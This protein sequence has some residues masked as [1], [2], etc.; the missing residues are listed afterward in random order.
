MQLPRITQMEAFIIETLRTHAVNDAD[1]IQAAFS[2]DLDKYS[3]ETSGLDYQLIERLAH[4]KPKEFENAMY[5]GY[6][7]KFLTFKGLQRVLLLKYDKKP[8]IDYQLGEQSINH[9]DVHKKEFQ[10]LQQILSDNWTVKQLQD[11]ETGKH[12]SFHIVPS[13]LT[14]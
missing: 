14:V 13:T 2:R 4:V 6:Q 8:E 10:S 12:H 3:N 9:L 11:A 7:I 5:H 1:I